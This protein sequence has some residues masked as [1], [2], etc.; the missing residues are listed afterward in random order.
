LIGGVTFKLVPNNRETSRG[1]KTNW[2]KSVAKERTGLLFLLDVNV[3]EEW[4]CGARRSKGGGRPSSSGEIKR[5]EFETLYRL[6]VMLGEMALH[7]WGRSGEGG[8]RTVSN[9]IRRKGI[10][11]TSLR[12]NETGKINV[13]GH[14]NRDV[15]EETKKNTRKKETQ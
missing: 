11:R 12:K 14:I 2:G 10:N 4:C 7:F 1:Q 5:G 3:T 9:E 13:K 8:K 6:L 15:S